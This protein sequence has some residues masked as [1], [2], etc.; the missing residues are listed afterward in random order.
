[1]SAW[2]TI[3]ITGT[4]ALLA[5]VFGSLIRVHRCDKAETKACMVSAPSSSSLFMAERR[6]N[7]VSQMRFRPSDG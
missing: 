3:G 2:A 1:M 6:N 7:E 4:G 5:R